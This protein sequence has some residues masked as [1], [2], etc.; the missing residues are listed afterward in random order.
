MP[1]AADAVEVVVNHLGRRLHFDPAD[2]RG[3]EL[4]LRSGDVKEGSMRLVAE[5]DAMRASSSWRI[6]GP[7]RAISA[8][9]RRRP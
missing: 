5:R 4:R 7:L 1:D 6:T 8:R 3:A 9:V 2:A